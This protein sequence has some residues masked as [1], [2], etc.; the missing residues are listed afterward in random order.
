MNRNPPDSE[1]PLL[2]LVLYPLIWLG[3]KTIEWTD[4]L[5]AW[6]RRHGLRK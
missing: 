6:Q 5:H 1:T 4:R 2:I 3:A